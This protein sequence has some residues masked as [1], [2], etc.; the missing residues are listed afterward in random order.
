MG[1][2]KGEGLVLNKVSLP[3]VHPLPPTTPPPLSLP[4]PPL[5]LP[6]TYV[7]PQGDESGDVALSVS[8]EDA[9]AD[10]LAQLQGLLLHRNWGDV[11]SPASDEDLLDTASDVEVA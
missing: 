10:E 2:V 8:D 7:A 11:L 4:S 6:S 3:M 1:V 9:V 5:P